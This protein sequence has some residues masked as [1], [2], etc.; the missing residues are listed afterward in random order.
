MGLFLLR[1]RP[2][3]SWCKQMRRADAG[4]LFKIKW[5]Y[6]SV[7]WLTVRVLLKKHNK[8]VCLF[9]SCPFFP[10]LP[11]T[12]THPHSVAIPQE[13]STPPSPT[14]GPANRAGPHGLITAACVLINPHLHLRPL[15]HC[16]SDS[17][18]DT[19]LYR[20]GKKQKRPNLTGAEKT[21]S[22]AARPNER[23]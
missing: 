9:F 20:R 8:D 12:K 15:I 11:I 6:L 13:C 2:S 3:A 1:W 4:L 22:T 18:K 21:G 16:S 7:L 17:P 14:Q 19:Q 10:C 23:T 5:R